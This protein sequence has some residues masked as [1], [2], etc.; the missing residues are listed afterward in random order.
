[1]TGR[2]TRNSSDPEDL[3]YRALSYGEPQLLERDIA[4][5]VRFF[6][7]N[8]KATN[9]FA[10]KVAKVASEHFPSGTPGF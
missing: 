2:P 9:D 1:M 8:L 3:K 7:D 4:G 10:K 6:G 5:K